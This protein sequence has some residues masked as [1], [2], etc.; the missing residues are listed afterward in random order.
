MAVSGLDMEAA[1]E[2]PLAWFDFKRAEP[3]CNIM[4]A[5]RE[6]ET[7]SEYCMVAVAY[8]VLMIRSPLNI[9][10]VRF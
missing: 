2:S 10:N 4:L 8:L 1:E 9:S 7:E 6:K 5:H 3:R